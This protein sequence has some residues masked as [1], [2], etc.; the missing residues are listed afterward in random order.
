MV[1]THKYTP[2]TLIRKDFVDLL[3]VFF[4]FG[5]LKGTNQIISIFS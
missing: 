5:F 3:V 1:P 2:S 4:L